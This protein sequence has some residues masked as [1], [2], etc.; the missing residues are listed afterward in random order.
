MFA[1]A[2]LAR[3]LVS[4][5]REIELRIDGNFGNTKLPV[6]VFTGIVQ[7]NGQVT[8]TG[9]TKGGAGE[10]VSISDGAATVG[11]ATTGTG[12]SFSLTVSAVASKT[13]AYGATVTDLAGSVGST[14]GDLIQGGANADTLTG[15]GGANSLVYRAVSNSMPRQAWRR[16]NLPARR[17][18]AECRQRDLHRAR[19]PRSCWSTPATRPVRL[20]RDSHATNM[21]IVLSAQSGLAGDCFTP[22][23][24][25]R[26]I[27]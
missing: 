2:F 18:R 4:R 17:H 27:T 12:G 26:P 5:A 20:R 19:G 14:A 1:V 16:A 25:Q 22:E 6:P 11:T 9:S 15:G 10:A 7:S 23:L 21:K 3:W 8:L 24:E 13:H